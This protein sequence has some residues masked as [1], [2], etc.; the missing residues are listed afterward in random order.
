MSPTKASNAPGRLPRPKRPHLVTQ[1]AISCVLAAACLAAFP[2]MVPSAFTIATFGVLAVLCIVTGLSLFWLMRL[3]RA[4]G[5]GLAGL[6]T[7]AIPVGTVMGVA[8]ILYFRKPV[9][10]ALFDGDARRWSAEEAEE[11]R[12]TNSA[13][14][15][16]TIV[17]AVTNGLGLLLVLLFVPLPR[18]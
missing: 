15:A 5:I 17:L 4:L 2:V 9:V 6:S 16:L 13:W 14:A 1:M 10:R 3:G 18:F 7:I 11:L 8:A 12:A